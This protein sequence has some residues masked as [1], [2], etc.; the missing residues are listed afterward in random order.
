LPPES[1]STPPPQAL[2]S[3]AAASAAKE[4]HAVFMTAVKT[5]TADQGRSDAISR[6]RA[7]GR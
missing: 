3:D 5:Q 2:A 6:A 1:G 7:R 4:S